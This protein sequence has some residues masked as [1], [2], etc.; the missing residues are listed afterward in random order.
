MPEP[1]VFISRNKIKPGMTDAFRQH[2]R[3][4]L[5]PIM[6]GKPNTLAQVAYENE[7]ADVVTIVR[8]FPDADA[9]DQQIQGADQ[10]LKKAYE[11]IEPLSIE[12]FGS[13]NPATVEMMKKVAGSGITV[14]VSPNYVGGFIR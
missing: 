10:R 14:S 3:D 1:I 4:S 7:A 11:L 13:P 2:Y 9:L 5:A 12:I 6:A 8:L